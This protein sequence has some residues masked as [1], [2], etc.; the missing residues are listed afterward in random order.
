[1]ENF[2]SCIYVS[3]IKIGKEIEGGYIIPLSGSS[4]EKGIFLGIK[5]TQFR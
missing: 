1:M 3:S 4:K 5:N 2:T